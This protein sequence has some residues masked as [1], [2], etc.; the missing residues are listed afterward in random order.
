LALNMQNATE[1]LVDSDIDAIVNE[2]LE[3]LSNNISAKL[4][5]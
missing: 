3:E 5:D 1:T 2:V 4:R